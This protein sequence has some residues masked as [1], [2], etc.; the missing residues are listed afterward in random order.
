MT[1]SFPDD[2]I[3][4]R[5]E[6]AALTAALAETDCSAHGVV[7]G[8]M[9]PSAAFAHCK[10]PR[11]FH[12]EELRVVRLSALADRHLADVAELR[13]PACGGPGHDGRL[14][15]PELVQKLVDGGQPAV[16]VDKQSLMA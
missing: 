1:G 8:R 2:V 16:H 15:E 9:P 6:L 7:S 13:E 3:V 5:V 14:R 10:R 11:R 4:D 12:R